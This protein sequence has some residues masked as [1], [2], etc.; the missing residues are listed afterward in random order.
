MTVEGY[1]YSQDNEHIKTLLEE[2]HHLICS[3]FPEITY[4]I[5][6]KIPVYDYYGL[7]CYLNP[8]KGKYVNIGF[9]NGIH[10]SNAAGLLTGNGKR[11]RL[12]PIYTLGDLQ[13]E[14]VIETI[15]E[16]ALYNETRTK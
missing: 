10:L 14:G 16:A 5:K 3:T 9:P 2:L 6:W 15:M 4:S 1:I 7:F 11:V 8:Q 13:K 12:L